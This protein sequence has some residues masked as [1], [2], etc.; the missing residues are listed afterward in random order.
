MALPF[1]VTVQVPMNFWNDNVWQVR[2]SKPAGQRQ[3]SLRQSP[4]LAQLTHLM[5]VVDWGVLSLLQESHEMASRAII[6]AD[7]VIVLS[8]N[9][10]GFLF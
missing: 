8:G 9:F 1:S 7:V 3:V 4:P 5:T 6:T 10:I 2:P